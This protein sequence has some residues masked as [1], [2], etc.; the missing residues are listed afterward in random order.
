MIRLNDESKIIKPVQEKIIQ[1][2]VPRLIEKIN[3][4]VKLIKSP[5]DSY[6]SITSKAES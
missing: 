5:L 2:S 6:D 3:Q 4:E 1:G